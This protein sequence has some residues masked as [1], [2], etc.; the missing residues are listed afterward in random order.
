MATAAATAANTRM[1]LALPTPATRMVRPGVGRPF[2]ARSR[3]SLSTK[4]ASEIATIIAQRRMAWMARSLARPSRTASLPLLTARARRASEARRRSARNTRP[5]D[6]M[7]TVITVTA[8]TG[9]WPVR[10][11]MAQ[12]E[13]SKGERREAEKVAPSHG[14]A[15]TVANRCRVRHEYLGPNGELLPVH[16]RRGAM[17]TTLRSLA[18]IL[19][20]AVLLI[21]GCSGPPGSTGG[22]TDGATAARLALAQDRRF[23]GIGPYDDRAIGQAAW[24]KVADT[25]DGWSVTIRMGWGDCP[26]GCINEHTWM[27]DVTRGG[28]VTPAGERGDPLPNPQSVSGRAT[29][30][31][32]CPVERNPPDPACAARP[33]AGAVLVIHDRAGAGVARVTTD[34]DGRFSLTLAPGAY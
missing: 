20:A 12:D 7:P 26:A 13:G 32:T 6:R 10:S 23:A 1:G 21:V 27:Y 3:F 31:P 30:G 17:K 15:Q 24:Y 8:H 25:N 5:V 18:V 11:R 28:Q 14:H 19:A 4:S 2:A 33:V 29:A 9:P 16:S 22:V 34:K